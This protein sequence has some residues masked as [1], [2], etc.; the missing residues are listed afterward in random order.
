MH[1]EAAETEA[2]RSVMVAAMHTPDLTAVVA[3]SVDGRRAGIDLANEGTLRTVA[4]DAPLDNAPFCSL[5]IVVRDVAVVEDACVLLHSRVL[6]HVV[7]DE[8][9]LGFVVL[10]YDSSEWIKWPTG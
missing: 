6:D 9:E 1:R 7:L 5:L 8:G 3:A 4:V 2:G 10:L